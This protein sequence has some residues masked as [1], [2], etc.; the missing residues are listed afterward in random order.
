M[1][2]LRLAIMLMAMLSVV[3]FF[4][5]N[6]FA[7]SLGPRMLDVL[8]IVFVVL[9]G[10]YV[11]WV[12]GQLWIVDYI[13][14]SSVIVLANWFPLLLGGLAAVLWLRMKPNPL[15]R[16]L[17]VQML[18]VGATVLSVIYVIPGQQLECDDS[19]IER[20][21]GFPFR[22]CQQT[23]P[24]TC[25]AAASATL[26][27]AL[28]IKTNESEM[29]ELCLTR[30][31]ST[32]LGGTTWLGMYHGLR[33]K[34]RD[35]EYVPKFFDGTVEDLRHYSRQHPVILCCQLT[36]E[37]A[38]QNPDLVHDEGWIPGVAHTVVYFGRRGQLVVIGDPSQRGLEFWNVEDLEQLW[39][40]MGI[41]VVRA[42]WR[43]PQADGRSPQE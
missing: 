3:V 28:G 11:R 1:D 2:D 4:G 5:V 7:R 32:W 37:V 21:P 19:W 23:T 43:K 42:D 17:P 10:L 36:N 38:A 18:L 35:S 29:A 34:M 39:T 27:D 24:V 20:S 30:D 26:L 12:W 22:V 14:L 16:R 40:G 41:R 33:V 25:S 8:A 6:R 15:W 31:G 13:P 9:I